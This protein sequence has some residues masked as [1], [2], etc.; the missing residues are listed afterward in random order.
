METLS[1]EKGSE[2]MTDT[3]CP[4]CG[5]IDMVVTDRHPRGFN[6]TGPGGGRLEPV[7]GYVV[8]A[9]C[10]NSACGAEFERGDY[11]VDWQRSS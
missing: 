6:T 1:V 3:A 10:Q 4:T 5:A 8:R 11:A 9:R 2:R 7:H